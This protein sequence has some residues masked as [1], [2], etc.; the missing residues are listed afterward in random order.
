MSSTVLE[1]LTNYGIPFVALVVCL[2]EI[3]VPTGIP[4]EILLLLAASY[5]VHSVPALIAAVVAVAVADIVGT[6]TLHQVA[7]GHGA[8]LLARFLHH[9]PGQ[10]GFVAWGR[11]RFGGRD[12]IW[13]LL[14]RLIP[15]VRM[16]VTVSSGVLNVPLRQFLRG[17]VPAS[18][19]W[20]GT[21]LVVGYF[22]RADVDQIE[23]RY[24]QFSRLLLLA[25]P[26]IAVAAGLAWWLR[27][28]RPVPRL[29]GNA[30][31]VPAAVAAVLAIAGWTFRGHERA[32]A[33]GVGELAT[34]A[35][36]RHLAVGGVL[37][38][39]LAG[40]VVAAEHGRRTAFTP[41]PA[42]PPSVGTRGRGEQ[43]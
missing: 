23:A 37:V 24:G 10:S 7:R 43:A 9:E 17:A 40:L 32:A 26:V 27:R 33:A 4:S 8:R 22:F 13:I 6:T 15:I 1:L 21:P 25:L 30:W 29:R 20:A 42:L 18:L 35:V 12:W 5:A 34:E 3:G 28:G 2:G 36:V 11:R 39:V 19:V 41:G 31:P 38:A 16:P 14:G